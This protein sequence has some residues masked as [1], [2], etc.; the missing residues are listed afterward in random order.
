[1]T[2]I[3]DRIMR[4]LTAFLNV[5]G[6]LSFNDDV[7]SSLRLSTELSSFLSLLLDTS[8]PRDDGAV[9]T[10]GGATFDR[11]RAARSDLSCGI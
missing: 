9:L 3:I 11:C 2:S 4:R 10:A 6:L 7:T 8:A 1:L 5:L